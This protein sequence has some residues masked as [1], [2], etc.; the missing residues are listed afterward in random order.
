MKKYR[1]A[2][3]GANGRMGKQLIQAVLDHP[4]LTLTVASVR[5]ES[6]LAG[7][8][9]GETAGCGHLNMPLITQLEKVHEKFDLLIDFTSPQSSL[10]NLQCCIQHNK[11]IIIGT[12]GF[13][14]Q[15]RQRLQQAGRSIPVLFAA[16][17]SIGV[18]LMLNLVQEAARVMGNNADIEILEA[19]HRNKVDAPS[20]TAL[21]IGE[22]IA[23]TLG[24]S[25]NEQA[26]YSREGHTGVRP[27]KSIGFATIRAGDIIGE[28]SALFANLDEQIVITHKATNRMT[29]ANGAVDAAYWIAD[30]PAGFYSMRDVLIK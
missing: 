16:N 29:F 1:V 21:A 19:H 7:L 6:T 27:E 3:A 14:D 13:T 2:I 8:D 20:G 28:H 26:V 25:L 5:E 12:T 4:E 17:F 18:N 9:A 23:T 10:H 30:K 15:Q 11:A 24:W 22:A